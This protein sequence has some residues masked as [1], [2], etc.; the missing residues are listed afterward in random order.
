MAVNK[1]SYMAKQF[2]GL[3]LKSLIG[4][5]LKAATDANGM[6]ARAQTQLILSTCFEKSQDD[7]ERLKPKMITFVLERTILDEDGKPEPEPAKMNISLP[8]L[9]IVPLNSLAVE[10]LK[11]SFEMDVKS[12]TEYNHEKGEDSKNTSK[13]AVTSDYK[14]DQYTVEM[15]GT[16]AK[17]SKNGV[18]NK[19]STSARYE[20]ELQAGQLPLPKGLTTIIDAFTKNIAP[21]QT[22]KQ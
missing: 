7:D 20:I 10:T 12:S 3:P 13:G 6:M 5:P 21:I 14:G 15:H 22:K 9:T 4:A 19:N 16:L 1:E 8:L 18:N 17:S 11:V 2:S